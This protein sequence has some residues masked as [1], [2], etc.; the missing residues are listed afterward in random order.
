VILCTCEANGVVYEISV[1][2]PCILSC[3]STVLFFC[4]MPSSF[5]SD[6]F[7]LEEQ[8]GLIQEV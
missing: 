8:Q 4:S 2:Y 5:R 6:V 3:T 1:L 7:S